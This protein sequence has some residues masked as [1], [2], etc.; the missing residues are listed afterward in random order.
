[1]LLHGRK[2]EISGLMSASLGSRVNGRHVVA[3][4]EHL[5]NRGIQYVPSL[6]NPSETAV[7]V[8]TE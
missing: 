4:V 6:L 7:M 1:M 3:I 8:E 2:G 5:I